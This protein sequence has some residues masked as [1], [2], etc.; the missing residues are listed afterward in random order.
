MQ[1]CLDIRQANGIGISQ[2]IWGISPAQFAVFFASIKLAGIDTTKPFG[3]HPQ[4]PFPDALVLDAGEQ[5]TAA[6][7]DI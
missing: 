1:H 3:F 2:H 6:Q 4:N 7:Y 5:A